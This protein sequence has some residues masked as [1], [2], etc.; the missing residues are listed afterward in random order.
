MK[1]PLSSFSFLALILSLFAPTAN[2]DGI[3]GTA[4]SFAVL[5]SST[6]VNTGPTTIDG[7]LGVSPGTSITGV[8]SIT[9]TGTVHQTDAVAAQALKDATTGYNNLA[10]LTPTMSLTGKDLGGLTLTKGVYNFASSAQL[11]GPLIINFQGLDNVFVVF[12][13]GSTLTTASGSSVSVIN[14][15]AN[16]GLYWDVG[17]SATLGTSTSFIG[18]ILALQSVTMNTTAKDGCGRVFALNAAVT[19]DT[20]VISNTCP[21]VGTTGTTVGTF[22]G[23]VT[24]FDRTNTGVQA[25]EVG[26]VVP[27]GSTV[28]TPEPATFALL[29]A[30]LL[31]LGLLAL[32][33]VQAGC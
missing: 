6:V 4:S 14:A 20:N 19:M 21:L 8:G 31:P 12:Q 15:G 29:L 22:G 3:L 10:L 25:A 33:K 26:T 23:G 7:N 1:I 32:R 5:G 30:G 27:T 16:D 2:A 28:A 24:V 9:L 13:I 17:S 11:T 18:N